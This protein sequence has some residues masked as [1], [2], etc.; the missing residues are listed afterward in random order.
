MKCLNNLIFARLW[1][2]LSQALAL[3]GRYFAAA[4]EVVA[5]SGAAMLQQLITVAAP[6]LDEHGWNTVVG[7]IISICREDHLLLV[8]DGESSWNTS[9]A[10]N[11]HEPL[12]FCSPGAACHVEVCGLSK[13]PLKRHGE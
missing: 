5:A 1:W 9:S 8:P 2:Y 10:P 11:L 13:R 7:T 3:L 4:D 12:P 6:S